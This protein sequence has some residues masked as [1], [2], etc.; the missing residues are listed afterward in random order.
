V[1]GNTILTKD[2]FVGQLDVVF[3]ALPLQTDVAE[4]LVTSKPKPPSCF[5]L[6]CRL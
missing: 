5:I 4:N 1:I 6:F 2:A 3:E